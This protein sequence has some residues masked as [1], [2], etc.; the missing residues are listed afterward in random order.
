MPLR[1]HGTIEP[2]HSIPITA[3]RLTGQVAGPL[4][5]VHLAAAGSHVKAGDLLVEFDRAT[6]A[7]AAQDKEAEYRDDLAHIEEKRGEQVG[8][9][10]DEAG[11]GYP[12]GC[13]VR[14]SRA[15]RSG[16]LGACDPCR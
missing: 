4:V 5:I 6:Q 15:T 9:E 14:R 13:F 10:G 16:P 11:N 12:T 2:V 7:K 3:P 1:L 8:N